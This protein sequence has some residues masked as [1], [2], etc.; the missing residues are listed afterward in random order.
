MKKSNFGIMGVSL[1]AVIAVLFATGTLSFATQNTEPATYDQSTF[2]GHLVLV[3]KDTDGN[4]KAY[5]QSDNIVTTVGKSCA[6]MEIFGQSTSNTTG[7]QQTMCGGGGA[8]S[9]LFNYVGIGTDAT[10]EVVGNT[11]LAAATGSRQ[12][13]TG[14]GLV[15]SSGVYAIIEPSAFT[16]LTAT[17]REAGLFDALTGNHMF[18]R[19][20]FA[21]IGLTSSDS[22]TV[23]WRVSVT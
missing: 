3:Q 14:V 8:N 22:L 9:G 23:T 19:K 10:G 6:I 18:A 2:M 16:G 21:D 11:A 20:T 15:N 4:I 5:R 1:S 12:Q 7:S 13:D 17:I